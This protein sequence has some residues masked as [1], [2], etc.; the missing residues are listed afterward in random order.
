MNKLILTLI[1]LLPAVC[2]ARIITVDDDGPADFNN[3][4]AAI[5]NSNNGDTIVVADGRYTGPGNRNIDFKGKDITVRSENGPKTCIIDCER[6]DRAFYFHNDENAGSILDGFTIKNGNAYDGGAIYCYDCSPAI[7]NCIFSGNSSSRG[8]GGVN[9]LHSSPTITNCIFSANSASDDGGGVYCSSY[10]SPTITNCIFNNNSAGQWYGRGAGGGIF[11]VQSSPRIINCVIANNDAGMRGGGIYCVSSNN[12]TITNCTIIDNSSHEAG[13]GIGGGICCGGATVTNCIIW[14]NFG[15]EIRTYTGG[16]PS[17]VTFCDIR[18]GW[19]GEGNINEDP[20]LTESWHLCKGSPCIDSGVDVGAPTHDIDDESRPMGEAI[21]IG[22]DEFV[23]I[24]SDGLP[25]WWESRYFHDPVGANPI[26]DCDSDGWTNL[27]EYRNDTMPDVEPINYYIDP[28]DGNDAYDGLSP[29]WDGHS[30]PKRT[31]QTAIDMCAD[32]QNDKVI[33]AEGTYTGFGNRDLDFKGKAITVSS[34]DPNDAAVVATT[35]IDC[36]GNETEEHRGFKFHS[37][38]GPGSLITGLTITNGYAPWEKFPGYD[39]SAG[40]A[41]FCTWASPT[42]TKCTIR[43]NNAR[44]CG[45]GICFY[46]GSRASI[47]VCNIRSNGSRFGGG[48]I[49]CLGSDPI[50]TNSVITTNTSSEGGGIYFSGRHQIVTNCIIIGNRCLRY[51]GGIYCDSYS[52]IVVTN[53]TVVGNTVGLGGRGGGIYNLS[54]GLT[55]NNSILWGNNSMWYVNEILGPGSVTYSDVRYGC[56]GLGNIDID[57]CFVSPGYWD[58]NGTPQDSNDDFWVN[59]DF[60]LKSQAGRWDPVSE[61]WVKDDVTSR[62][63][64][65]GN[66]SSPVGDEPSPNG[67]RINMGAYGGTAEAS[68]SPSGWSL[69]ADLTNDG[70]VNLHDFAYTASNWLTTTDTQP[71]DLNRNAVVDLADFALFADDWLEETTWHR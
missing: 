66:P 3:I 34:T 70:I 64:D 17:T 29:A 46:A 35:V 25:D 13:Y 6:K 2:Q 31:I 16:N 21:D 49:Y 11:C 39:A 38:E 20:K 14:G 58:P 37:G 28:Q 36:Q 42:I 27:Q 57:P 23:D 51:G 71:G 47:T 30:G 1:C 40:G 18:G 32:R 24:D 22:A 63:I 69:L 41:I 10:S 59:G 43:E 62:C 26:S 5:D 52:D 65:A 15:Q 54:R 44:D 4:Q 67:N 7:T 68:K 56:Q 50:V 12:P 33:L 48:G 60:H 53:C 9:C 55:V 19:E 61:S 45:G 8:G